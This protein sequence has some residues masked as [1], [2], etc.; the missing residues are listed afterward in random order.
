MKRVAM[1]LAVGVAAF[2]MLAG[3]SADAQIYKGKRVTMLIN[4]GAGG[5]TDIEGRIVA[6]HLPKH[7]PGNP[8]IIVKNLPGGGG[9]IASNNLGE[10]AKPDGMTFGFFTWNVLAGMIG[11]PGLRVGYDKFRFVAG[12]ANPVV[13]YARK[14]TAPGLS[15]GDDL[16]K[17][18]GFKGCSLNARNTNTIQQV[19]ALEM[20]GIDHKP[21]PGYRGLKAVEAAVLKGECQVANS[22]LPGWK[23]SIIPTMGKDVVPVFQ[24]VAPD[25]SGKI[26]RAAALSDIPTFE[27]YY[28]KHKGS[29]PSGPKYDALRKIV[30]SFMAMFRTAFA[31]PGAPDESV[32]ALRTAFQSMWKDEEF[33]T[34]Y[35]KR[36]KNRPSLIVGDAGEKRIAGLSKIDPKLAALFN[37]YIAKLSK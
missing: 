25:E 5:P 36:V 30:D 16:M 33:L 35:E 3:T 15:S 14:D 17:A 37:D 22:S 18:K 21:V 6:R 24:L 26:S 10:I 20:L 9:M 1:A 19:L 27:E 13:L 2:G 29:A 23:G 8:T 34:E 28:Q 12:I 7:I 32:A 31:A 4:Y 11:D